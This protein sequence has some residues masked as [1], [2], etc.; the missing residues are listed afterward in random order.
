MSTHPLDPI[1]HPRTVALFGMPTKSDAWGAMF[2]QSLIDSGYDTAKMFLINPNADEIAGLPCYH[3][4]LDVPAEV[5]HVISLVP[6]RVVPELVDQCV[7]KGVRSVHLF[8][9][10]FSETGE[11]E[12]AKVERECVAKLR[13][14][15]IR[16][17][18]P[19]CLGLYVPASGMTFSS[20]FPMESGNVFLVSQSGANAGEI[21]RSLTPRGVRFSKAVSFG[22]GA[23]LK[24]HDFFDYAANDPDTDIV[25]S[26]LEGVSHGR[27]LF[28]SLKR[29]AAVKPTIILKGGLSGAGARAANSHTGSLAGSREVFEAMCRQ[30]GAIRVE[31]MEELQDLTVAIATSVRTVAGRRVILV[32][33]PGGFAVLSSDAIAAQ[34]LELPETPEQA[35]R[36]I[37]EFIPVAGTSVNNPIDA[38]PRDRE[39]RERMMHILC[40]SGFYDVVFSTSLGGDP[41]GM[42]GRGRGRGRAQ[43]AEPETREAADERAA[44]ETERAR[45]AAKQLAALQSEVGIP[46]LYVQRAF[47]ESANREASAAFAEGIGAFPTVLRAARTVRQLLDWRA[48]REGLQSIF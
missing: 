26:Y 41:G 36:Q 6:A 25:I 47:G 43:S 7:A 3:T 35:K 1:F 29:C 38:N 30:V 33:G 12:L 2:H 27:E 28:E 23:D 37:R 9:A 20:E 17:I 13:A 39:Q 42:G 32:G 21:V 24:A 40:D 48:R 11:A 19:N 5:D 44:A 14:A 15:G 18:G 46:I 45:G 16:T 10:G 34:E 31:S 4:L 22:N 8:T